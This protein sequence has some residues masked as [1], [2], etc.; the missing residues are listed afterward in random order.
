LLTNLPKK[1]L[2]RFWYLPRGLK[3]TVIMTGDDHATGGTTGRFDQ[4]ISLSPSNTQEAVE[5][6]TAIRSTSYI[7]PDTDISDSQAAAYE[8]L[9]FEISI[10]LNTNCENWTPVSWRNFYNAQAPLLAAQLPSIAS[11]STHRIHC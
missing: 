10:H 5:D 9:G 11:S 8:S 2:P 4:Y 6:W 1:P 3:A 7:F